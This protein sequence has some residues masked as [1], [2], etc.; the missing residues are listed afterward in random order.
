MTQ[1]LYRRWRLESD[2]DNHTTTDVAGETYVDYWLAK[3]ILVPL[4]IRYAQK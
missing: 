4:E 2:V 3:D 1:V